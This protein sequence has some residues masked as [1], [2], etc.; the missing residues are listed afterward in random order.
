MMDFLTCCWPTEE[1]NSYGNDEQLRPR[2]YLNDGKGI[3][4]RDPTAFE[5]FL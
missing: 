3:F 1:M 4:T 2:I 5:A